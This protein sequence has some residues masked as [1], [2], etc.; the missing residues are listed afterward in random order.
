MTATNHDGH[1]VYHDGHNH[2][3]HKVYHYGHSN[4]NVKTNGILLIISRIHWEFTVIPYSENRFVAVIV[5]A[6]HGRHGRTP[7][8][9]VLTN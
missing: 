1:K 3:G 7:Y 2:D 4:E 5:C 9:S 8:K 6:H